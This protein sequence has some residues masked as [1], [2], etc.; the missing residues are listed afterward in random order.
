MEAI[1]YLHETKDDSSVMMYCHIIDPAIIS[2]NVPSE[3]LKCGNT[4]AVA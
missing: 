2:R 3:G 1:N 4:F